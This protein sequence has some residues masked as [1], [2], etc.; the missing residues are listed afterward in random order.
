VVASLHTQIDNRPLEI[1]AEPALPQLPL[2]RRLLKLALKQV[3]DNALKYS[4][5]RSP[6][7]VLVSN[8]AGV[9]NFDITDRGPGIPEQ[10]QGRLFERFY[11]S[12]SVKN[13][14][15]GFG[16]GLAIANS[17][18]QAHRGQLI[19]NSRPGETT[20]RVTLPLGETEEP[21][22]KEPQPAAGSGARP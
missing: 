2:D 13:Q 11:R 9:V 8:G 4:P 22:T 16:L 15:P 18:V 6:I 1:R 3:L 10:E 12:P 14:V 5:S 19:V 20:F 7:S 21:P 17:I